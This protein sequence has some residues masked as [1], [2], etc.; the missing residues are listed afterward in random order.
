MERDGLRDI[1]A[2]REK[3]RDIIW[4]KDTADHSNTLPVVLE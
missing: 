4:D 3:G 2:E 1:R